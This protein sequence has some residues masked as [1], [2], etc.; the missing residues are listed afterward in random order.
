[1]ASHPGR[2]PLGIQSPSGLTRP[3]TAA[4]DAARAIVHTIVEDGR[5]VGDKLPSEAEMLDYYG[6]SRQSLR[7]AL[8]LLE[9][10][11]LIE[12]KRGPGGGPVVA[13]VD[14]GHFGRMSSLPFHLIG[15]TYEE[16]VEAWAFADGQ[17]AA[18]VARR[19]PHEAVRT[20]LD[21]YLELRPAVH[22]GVALEEYVD[23]H[24]RF[25][26]T[27]GGL[28][29]NKAL[30]LTLTSFGL[31]ISHHLL[32]ELDPRGMG[33]I[34]EREHLDIA[35]AVIAGDEELARKL[36]EDHVHTVVNHYVDVTGKSLDAL[37]EWR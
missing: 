11:G 10:Q 19:I 8:R 26:Y 14:A 36:S 37:V 24:T 31:V 29:G 12:L 1:M 7:E 16:L 6:V 28:C 2:A 27:L 5:Q 3:R 34:I 15:V 22:D 33:T 4:E 23:L 18:L 20:G 35:R 17:L 32:F 25:H 21:P 9:V 13:G 30:E